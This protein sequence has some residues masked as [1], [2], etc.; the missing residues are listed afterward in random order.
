MCYVCNKL[1]CKNTCSFINQKWLVLTSV[2]IHF[3]N[4]LQPYKHISKCSTCK[5]LKHFSHQFLLDFVQARK[6]LSEFPG[7]HYKFNSFLIALKDSLLS[8]K[9]ALQK[10]S[11]SISHNQEPTS[12]SAMVVGPRAPPEKGYW[13][14]SIAEDAVEIWKVHFFPMVWVLTLFFSRFYKLK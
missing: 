4:I 13:M 10:V 9:N 8:L 2:N 1:Q 11:K 12:W 7:N 5:I 14:S 3:P 6:T